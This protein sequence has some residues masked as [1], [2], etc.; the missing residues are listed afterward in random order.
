MVHRRVGAFERGK[1]WQHP[2]LF[3]RLVS[4]I[5]RERLLY[6]LLLDEARKIIKKNN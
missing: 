5:E 6:E 4:Y 1:L 2:C 3:D